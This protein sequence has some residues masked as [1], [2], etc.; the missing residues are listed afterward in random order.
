MKKFRKVVK[1]VDGMCRLLDLYNFFHFLISLIQILNL[2]FQSFG[3]K[4]KFLIIVQNPLNTIF[5][6]LNIVDLFLPSL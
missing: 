3:K 1:I 6:V 4:N 5:N 2:A